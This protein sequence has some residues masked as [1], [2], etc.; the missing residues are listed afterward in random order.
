CDLDLE[1]LN[2]IVQTRSFGTDGFD[3]GWFAALWIRTWQS[4]GVMAG[5]Q[6]FPGHGRTTMDSHATLPVVKAGRELERDLLPFR[7]AVQAGVG[8]ALIR[9][10]RL[11]R[12]DPS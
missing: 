6:H 10:V 9:A 3:V 4:A 1:P 7:R 5:A 11:A 8:S 12:S 2:P